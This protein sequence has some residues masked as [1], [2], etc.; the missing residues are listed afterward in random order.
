MWTK[1]RSFSS[2]CS[3]CL[4]AG[5]WLSRNTGYL[6]KVFCHPRFRWFREYYQQCMGNYSWLQKYY[7]ESDNYQKMGPNR[8]CNRLPLFDPRK[9]MVGME[10]VVCSGI[11]AERF[12]PI[13][14]YAKQ[15]TLEN[16]RKSVWGINWHNVHNPHLHVP[17]SC[18]ETAKR[19]RNAMRN[20][21]LNHCSRSHTE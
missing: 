21:T 14:I 11:R 17:Q 16:Y 10:E 9:Y 20:S 5:L 8:K 15:A 3:N 1:S 6:I 12:A 19:K 4:Y 7:R 13:M 2:K 18:S